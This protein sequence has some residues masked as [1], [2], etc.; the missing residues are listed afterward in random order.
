MIGNQARTR[1]IQ[2]NAARLA[3]VVLCAIIAGSTV[4]RLP[5]VAAGEPTSVL[6]PYAMSSTP[7]QTYLKTGKLDAN[8]VFQVR[9][10][11][12]SVASGAQYIPGSI[13][14]YGIAIWNSG[15]AKGFTSAQRT[16]ILA[17]VS[18]MRSA[19]V[20]RHGAAV[21]IYGTPDPAFGATGPW[22]SS[23]AEGLALSLLARADQID[24]QPWHQVLGD[25]VLKAF[26]LS[27]DQGGLL[28]VGADR[29]I[30]EGVA[31]PGARSAILNN[32]L[33][34]LIGLNDYAVTFKSSIAQRLYAQG[35]AWLTANLSRYDAGWTS[36]YDLLGHVAAVGKDN[37]LSVNL[38]RYFA[39]ITG[40]S[41]FTT[42]ANVFAGYETSLAFIATASKSY[43]PSKYGASNL[44]L[45]PHATS[46]TYWGGP[47]HATLTLDL[48]ATKGISAVVLRQETVTSRPTLINVS[49]SS[50]GQS[51]S[52]PRAVTLHWIDQGGI[53]GFSLRVHAEFIRLEIVNAVQKNVALNYIVVRAQV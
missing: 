50:D 28:G 51:W 6:C 46:R 8:G 15:C 36:R 20:Y 41:I 39:T 27:V 45:D 53:A 44:Y 42:F 9:S 13:F 1:T 47:L 23:F 34:S 43:N 10:A 40:K 29:G 4:Q 48:G 16:G 24:A 33:F 19:A 18:W 31:Y 25:N 30:Y 35:L 26:A 37:R 49:T 52:S 2:A 38:L 32:F 7:P 22:V 21:W 14:S 5:A 17:Q 12:A 3:P 11:T